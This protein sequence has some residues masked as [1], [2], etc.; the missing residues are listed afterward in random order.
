MEPAELST[1]LKHFYGEARKVSARKTTQ[2]RH[3]E[4]QFVPGWT[5]FYVVL[6]KESH[7][8]YLGKSIQA[9]KQSF[10]FIT[11]R[12]SATGIDFFYKAQESNFQQR[13]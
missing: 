13:P 3:Y 2:L 1:M 9:G 12:S 8:N 4:S 6:F 11:E 5:D 7:F 10:R